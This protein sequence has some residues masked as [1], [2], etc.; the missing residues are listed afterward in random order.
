[1]TQN[2]SLFVRDL[3]ARL[4]GEGVTLWEEDGKL[5]YRAPQGVLAANDLQTLK[6]NKLAIL[7][8]LELQHKPI[9]VECDPDSRYEPFP[10]TDVQS[11]YLLGRSDVF[12]YGGVAC[13]IYL[14]LNYID[15]EHSRVEAVWNQLI[16]R[17]DMLR[18]VI[19]KNSYQQVMEHVPRFE[20]GFTDA[21]DWDYDKV[22]ASLEHMRTEMGH[23][24]YD[25]SSWP[26]FDVA[27]THTPNHAVLHFSIEFLVADWA[28]IWLLLSE[29]EALYYNRELELPTYT[30]QFRDYLIAERSL[31]ESIAYSRDKDYWFRRLDTLPAAPDLPLARQHNDAG[32]AQFIRRYLKMDAPTWNSFKQRA[33]RRGLTPTTAVMTAYAAVIER[34]SRNRSFCLNLTVLNRLPLHPEV[35]QIVGDF[36]SVSLLAVDWMAGNT[37][38]GQ[39]KA[40]NSQLFADLDHRLF[41]GVE[42]LREISRRRGRDAALMPFVF[43]SAIGLVEATEGNELQGQVQGQGISQTPQVFIDCQAMDRASGLQV[44]W[45][46]REGVF[47]TGMAEDM[48]AVFETLLRLLAES[49]QAW[50]E[51]VCIALPQWQIDERKQMN[52]TAAPLPTDLL[53]SGIL[54]QVALSPERIAVVDSE[55]QFTYRELILLAS[56]V[57]EQL[58]AAGCRQQDLVA[59]VM[60]KSA[61]QLAAVLGV[62]GAGAVY[63]PIDVHQPELRRNAILDKTEAR[64]VLTCTTSHIQWPDHI[65]VI[66]VD[67]LE[68]HHENTLM[69]EGNP[70]VPAYIIHTSGSTGQ[71]KGVVI[72]H[73]SAANTIAGLNSR[74]H[75]GPNDTMLGLAQLS[76]DLSVY[77]IFGMLSAGGTLIL[78]SVERMTDPSHWTELMMQHEVT[79][80]NSVPALMQMLLAYLQVEPQI[81]LP[82]FRL[83]W[84]SG[85]W[86]PMSLP[87]TLITRVPSVQVISLGGATEASIWS[88]FHTYKGLQQDWSSIPYGRPLANQGF[89]ILDANMRDCAVWVPGELYITGHGLATE[90]FGDPE[91][92]EARFLHHP[93]DGQRLYRTG[94][95]GRYTPGGEIE[96][97]GREDNQ[98]KIKG[99][100]IELGE[101]ESALTKHPAVV[102]AA[103]VVDGVGDDKSLLGYVETA[104][105]K[106]CSREQEVELLEQMVDGIEQYFVQ[107]DGQG[108]E[109]AALNAMQQSVTRLLQRVVS[110]QADRPLRMLQLGAGTGMSLEQMI[111][112]LE[113]VDV[114]FWYTD[115]SSELVAQAQANAKSEITSNVRYGVLNAE[116]DYRSQGFA[117]NNFD[118]VITD[119]TCNGAKD[120]ATAQR[121]LNELLCPGGWMILSAAKEDQAVLSD[122]PIGKSEVM[123]DE[124]WKYMCPARNVQLLVKRV[125]L[126]R[127]AVYVPN[128]VK[129]LSNYVPAHMMPT[130]IQIV[131]SMPLTSN[132]KM[133]RRE[134][135]KWNIQST[136]GVAVAPTDNVP[137][138][139]L[140]TLLS[141]QWAEALGLS[142][143]GQSDNFYQRG[144]DSLI[145]AQV[146][147]KLR[148]RLASESFGTD[149]PFDAL[150]RQMLNYPTVAELAQFIRPHMKKK[151]LASNE[152]ELIEETDSSSNAVLTPYGG[153]DD[154]LL[155]VVFHAGLGTMNCF[156]LLLAHLDKQQ[157]GPVVGIT[158]KDAE[159][160]C[161]IEHSSLIEHLAEDYAER[162]LALGHVKVQLIGYCLGG[163][164]AVEVARRLMEKGI[165]IVDLVLIDSHPVLYQIEDDLVI[166][167]LFV[168]NLNISLEQAGFSGVEAG[169]FERGLLHMFEAH[170]KSVPAG[171][172]LSIGGDEGLDR[173]GALFR[174]L[175]SL[176]LRERFTAYS[177]A[178][179]TY[180]GATMPVE[181]AEGLFKV[182]RQS[183]K[184]AC[185]TPLPYVGNIRFLLAQEAFTLLPGTNEMTLNYWQDICLGEFSVQEIAGN[186][187]TCIEDGRNASDLSDVIGN[188][189]V[190]A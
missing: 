6:E 56:A 115:V 151:E 40:I 41:S 150:L 160:Y 70:D 48:F 101:I 172:T 10:L 77:D 118:I 176:T 46:I 72:T 32:K 59:I 116:E 19:D 69:A 89:R 76:F 121:N 119:F 84:L 188:V 1:M 157:L 91:T 74:F 184:S 16:A 163:L 79:M 14:E 64:H 82:K 174:K 156:R 27:V 3:V 112:G 127:V 136:S 22:E 158:V 39:A 134:L 128:L 98:V 133:D 187:Y 124:V 8:F 131:D 47:P 114:H 189:L 168:P 2:S 49:E 166:E 139:P 129:F 125:K 26:L 165:D 36:T 123:A 5:R 138:D 50:D 63:V 170:G 93:V 148:E 145:M 25:T 20:V 190:Q 83:A 24:V 96:F 132:G 120:P 142:T 113:G 169:D 183:L 4:Q 155:R 185:F 60:D 180:N 21:S 65:T 122:W 161:T 54:E 143:I 175:D 34:W 43:T 102:A 92:T 177:D 62:L 80:W 126:D 103:V 178:V 94:D 33:Q 81:S 15:L 137:L 53:H 153:G 44:N 108:N 66:E 182:Y 68:P 162:L 78:P 86:I 75:V 67:E 9:T 37:F 57:R 73:R 107:V 35:N 18:A 110:K 130:N 106:D 100:R 99:H 7:E 109:A 30:L 167:S 146:A 173:V 90:Y 28:S 13:H 154:G 12:G 87:D 71:P 135:L 186:H 51:E 17:H 147:G 159:L 38:Q 61:Y 52:D 85:D 55:R 164:I 45:D 111:A 42:V 29:F 58:Q 104:R 23:R 144:A 97:I 152:L 88:I 181:M 95:L 11:A 117:S 149:I 105:K 171:A 141:Q 140:E 31:R 179:A